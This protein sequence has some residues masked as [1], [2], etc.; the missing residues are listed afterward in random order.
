MRSMIAESM[1]AIQPHHELERQHLA[2][3]LDWIASGVP[4]FRIAKPDRPPQHLVSYFALVDDAA[5]KVLLVD[6]RKAGLW[7]PGGGHVEPDEDRVATVERDV[8][9]DL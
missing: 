8:L 7:L 9:E 3:T 5:R 6:H 4:L 2:T 1:R